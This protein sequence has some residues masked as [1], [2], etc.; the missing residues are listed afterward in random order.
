MKDLLTPAAGSVPSRCQSKQELSFADYAHQLNA[1]QDIVG[2]L[3]M[4]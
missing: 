3:E 4:T 2:R 1:G